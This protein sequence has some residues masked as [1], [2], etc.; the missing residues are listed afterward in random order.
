MIADLEARV[1]LLTDD[2]FYARASIARLTVDLE[3]AKRQLEHRD[4]EIA[5]LRATSDKLDDKPAERPTYET[6]KRENV[7]LREKLQI[8]EER[9]MY[10]R[11]AAR[12]EAQS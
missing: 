7:A 8:E 5:M 6:L 12:K 10:W 9:S 2:L 3:Q 1:T 11:K 4:A